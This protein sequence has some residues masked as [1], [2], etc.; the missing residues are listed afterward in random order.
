MTRPPRCDEAGTWHHIFN[1]A[2]AKRPLFQSAK[3]YRYFLA[4]VAHAVR[5]GNIRVHKFV[6]M[7]N[8]FHLLAESPVGCMGA[9][10]HDVQMLYARHMNR[11][12]GRDGPVFRTR[13][14]SRPVT[15]NVYRSTLV[16]YI[17]SNPVSA[18]T[19]ARSEAFPWGS[20]KLYA[21]RRRPLWLATEWV[22]EEVRAR[23]GRDS[24]DVAAYRE[25]FP[26][27]CDPDFVQWME[28]RLR[29]Q[30]AAR[31]DLDVVLGP[32]PAATLAWMRRQAE[33]ADGEDLVLPVAAPGAI[34]RAIA[35]A[36]PVTARL[37]WRRRP[38]PGA[39]VDPGQQ[40]RAGLLRDVGRLTWTEIAR[41]TNVTV[42]TSRSHWLSHRQTVLDDPLYAEH[43]TSIARVAAAATVGRAAA[44]QGGSPR[45][46]AA[47]HPARSG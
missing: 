12:L 46:G 30:A 17:D 47:A 33:L 14:G 11:R 41:L 32:D 42:S 44:C 29:S 6:L 35:A 22:D 10:M 1:R 15:S 9:A 23:T 45:H 4:R 39:A 13:Y 43:A 20:A 27:R 8:H 26:L 3:D 7:I 16:S 25:T 28:R 40:L 18:G 2:T 24:H 37:R 5:S 34:L 31:D 36:A 38:A 19:V 21:A